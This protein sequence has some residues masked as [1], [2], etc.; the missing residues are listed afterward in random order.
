MLDPAGGTDIFQMPPARVKAHR[1]HGRPA[2]PAPLQ[3]RNLRW[4]TDCCRTPIANTAAW[5]RFPSSASFI[6]SWTTRPATVPGTRCSARRS[7]A[8]RTLRRRAAPAER[9][10]RHR[11]CRLFA[12][13]ASK[14][15]GWWV[16]GLG[17]PT[18]FFDD[19]TKSSARGAARAFAQRACRSLL[20]AAL[21]RR[22]IEAATRADV[23]I[24]QR[25]EGLRGFAIVPI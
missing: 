3:T 24:L 21:D 4:Y 22:R 7:A 13:R 9:A 5:P 8:S 25:G 20:G 14:M 16:R 19:R 1:R 18:P 2:V 11:R 17:R 10:A 12:R 6:L 15:L 23:G